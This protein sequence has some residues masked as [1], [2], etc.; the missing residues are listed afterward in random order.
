MSNATRVA[1][2]RARHP[3]RVRAG[4]LKHLAANPGYSTDKVRAYRTANLEKYAYSNH[5]SGAKQRGIEFLFTFVEWVT[6]WGIDFAHRGQGSNELCMARI[7]DVGPYHPDNVKKITTKENFE[8][9][10]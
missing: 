4:R 6:W 2:Y 7:G 5:K 1:R 10:P 9:R 8:E 3:E